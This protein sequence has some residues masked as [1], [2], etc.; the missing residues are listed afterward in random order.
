MQINRAIHGDT[1]TCMIS[2]IDVYSLNTYIETDYRNTFY[3]CTLV[4]LH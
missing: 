4:Y 3:A 2:E 1:N